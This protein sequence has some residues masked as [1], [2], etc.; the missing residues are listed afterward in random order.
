VPPDFEEVGV[1]LA[2][3][4]EPLEDFEELGEGLGL[5]LAVGLGVLSQPNAIAARAIQIN[6]FGSSRMLIVAG[7][8]VLSKYGVLIGKKTSIL[9]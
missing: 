4:P 1:G 7:P 6:L 9:Q 2:V 3:P 8:F 5:E